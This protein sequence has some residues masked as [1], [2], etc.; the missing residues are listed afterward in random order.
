MFITALFTTAKIRKQ[1]KNPPMDEWIKKTWYMYKM[2]YYSSM[3][4]EDIIPFATTW[5]DF[6]HILLSQISQRSKSTG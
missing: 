5:M 6:E 2:E 1:S 3:R 4:K